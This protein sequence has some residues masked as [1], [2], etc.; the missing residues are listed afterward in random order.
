MKDESRPK[1]HHEEVKAEPKNKSKDKEKA[2]LDL[3]SKSKDK[4]K[5]EVM[6]APSPRRPHHPREEEKQ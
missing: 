1:R 4:A 5:K 2:K 6:K 3:K